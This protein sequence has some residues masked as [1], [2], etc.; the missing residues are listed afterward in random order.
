[1]AGAGFRRGAGRRRGAGGMAGAR[2][3]SPAARCAACAAGAGRRRAPG[4]AD[5]TGALGKLD[6]CLT[7]KPRCG[8]SWRGPAGAM[9]A[10]RRCPAMP[11]PAAMRGWRWRAQGHADGPAARRRS[12]RPRRPMPAKRRAAHWATMRWRGWP[13]P[14]APAS[15]PRRQWLRGHGLAAPDIYAADHAQGFV[16]LEDLGDA[17]FADVLA[18]GGD[19][20]AAVQGR[21][22][23]AGED[24]RRTTPRPRC[25]PTS[26]C[27]PM[28]RRR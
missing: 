11:P 21:R 14:T 28:T 5:R 19:E 26:R 3:R 15:S 20:E 9:P 12:A 18:D 17:L 2:A 8:I 22:R 23:S 4:A 7:A 25:R 27:S 6:S 24:P 13:A 10:S 1:M 16:I